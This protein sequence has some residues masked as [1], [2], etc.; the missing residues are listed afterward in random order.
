MLSHLLQNK[1]SCGI[2]KCKALAKQSIWKSSF[3]IHGRCIL[4]DI[5]FSPAF[6]GLPKIT[7][8]FCFFKLLFRT[9]RN[10]VCGQTVQG[11]CVCMHSL[12]NNPKQILQMKVEM[13]LSVWVWMNER[14]SNGLWQL[15]CNPS[16]DYKASPLFLKHPFKKNF[17]PLLAPNCKPDFLKEQPDVGR[18]A[19][20]QKLSNT[21][22][23]C[24]CPSFLICI[25]KS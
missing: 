6:C 12:K 3:S 4:I 13:E 8:M 19:P 11:K 16:I 22:A 25:Y 14:V 24:A 9:I 18:Q 1:N 23:G 5:S 7:G 17:F 2:I 10:T 20:N 15:L 21:F